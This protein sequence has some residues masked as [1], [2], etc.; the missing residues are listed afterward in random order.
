MDIEFEW[1]RDAKGYRPTDEEAQAP[2]LPSALFGPGGILAPE[3][4]FPVL[5]VDPNAVAAY[6][7]SVRFP[8]GLPE[9]PPGLAPEDQRL[10]I[11]RNGG[12]LVRYR[13]DQSADRVRIFEDF[14]KIKNA[15]GV[16]EFYGRWG[17][18]DRIGNEQDGGE[19]VWYLARLIS[20][21][22]Q[23]IDAWADPD[24][25][26]QTRFIERILGADGFGICDLEYVLVFDPQT[27][28]PRRRLRIPNLFA[29]LWMGM[30]DILM[31]DDTVLR[32]CGHCNELFAAG[33]ESGRRLDAKFCSDQHRVL[34]HRQKNA[35]PP[36]PEP[37]PDQP[38]RRGRPRKRLV[39]HG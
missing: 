1:E 34:Y 33:G 27:R 23:F 16:L 5:P 17:P 31:S 18:L 24:K 22:K 20:R 14:V 30:I 2:L 32:R 11:V 36:E 7:P 15:A 13:A 39:S 19:P 6:F 26:T 10:R 12:S 3:S 37:A 29:A 28:T 35:P 9:P 25:A 4:R 21:M 8:E 38:R